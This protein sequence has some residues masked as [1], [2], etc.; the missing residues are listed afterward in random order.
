MRARRPS[1]PRNLSSGARREWQRLAPIAHHAGTLTHRTAKAFELL[2]ETLATEVQARAVVAAEGITVKTG[3]DGGTKTHPAVKAM[4]TARAS[5][6]V[7]MKQFRLDA[8]RPPAAP[9]A[10]GAR[11]KPKWGDLPK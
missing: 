6:A 9:P 10:P 2:V 1:P 11:A 4:E 5:A 3:R 7:L 8:G